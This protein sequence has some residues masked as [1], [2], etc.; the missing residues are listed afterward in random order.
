MDTHPW[1]A[2]EGK[3]DVP[4]S[5][6]PKTRAQEAHDAQAA[7]AVRRDSDRDDPPERYRGVEPVSKLKPE[8]RVR[9]KL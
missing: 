1:N 4:S 6:V 9:R 3:Y 5:S 7:R 2:N 8:R